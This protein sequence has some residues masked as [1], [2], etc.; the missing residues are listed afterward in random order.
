VLADFLSHFNERFAIEPEEPEPAW[1]PVPDEVDLDAVC[2]FRYERVVAND[3]SVRIGG[4]V[5]DLPRRPDGRSLAGK[6]VEVRLQ[7]DGRLVV[8]DGSTQ[9]LSAETDLDP[10]RLRDLEKTRFSL[11]GALRPRRR[12]APGYAPSPDHPWR[13]ATPGSKLEA[14]RRAERG[15]TESQNS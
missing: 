3:A 4:L 14:I 11:K 7:L 2:A 1:R 13:R 15:L 9:L 10:G 6:H 12:E 5:L 8:A